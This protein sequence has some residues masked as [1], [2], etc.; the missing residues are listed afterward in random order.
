MEKHEWYEWIGPDGEYW[1]GAPLIVWAA[2]LFI[3]LVAVVI[4]VN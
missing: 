2:A 1:N 4:L 3:G